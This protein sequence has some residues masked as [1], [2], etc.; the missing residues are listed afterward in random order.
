M[1][2]ANKI[3]NIIFEVVE[4]INLQRPQDQQIKKHKDEI[5]FG[6]GKL[7]SLDLA[8]L[9]VIS[10][11]KINE[12]FSA[13]ITLVDEKAMSQQNSPFRSISSLTEYIATKLEGE[14]NE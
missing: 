3:T 5:L 10:E 9:I 13:S 2:Q 8:S 4:E 14:K 11:E 6:A 7:D 12:K 1:D